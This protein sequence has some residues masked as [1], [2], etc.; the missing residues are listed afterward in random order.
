MSDFTDAFS[1]E[2]GLIIFEEKI[3]VLKYLGL[4]KAP[5]FDLFQTFQTKSL[6]LNIFHHFF[7]NELHTPFLPYYDTQHSLCEKIVCMG[8]P[9]GLKY[10]KNIFYYI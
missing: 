6:F 3:T 2:R 10:I 9:E 8:V 4:Q 5:K 1:M 7:R